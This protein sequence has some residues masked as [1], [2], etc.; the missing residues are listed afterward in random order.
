LRRK[1]LLKHLIEE[2]IE[3]TGRQ[4]RKRNMLLDDFKEEEDPGN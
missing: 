3:V 1:T 2:K 4:G